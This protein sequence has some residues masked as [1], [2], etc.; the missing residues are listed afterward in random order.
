MPAFTKEFDNVGGVKSLTPAN[1]SF[2]NNDF[3]AFNLKEPPGARLSFTILHT[4]QMMSQSD[5]VSSVLAQF[6]EYD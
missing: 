5:P 2:I 6:T 1:A 4:M 3:Q